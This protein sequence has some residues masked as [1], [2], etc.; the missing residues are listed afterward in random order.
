[1]DQIKVFSPAT[2]SNVACGFDVLGFPLESLGD[3]MLVRKINQKGIKIIKNTGYS[4][5]L[6]NNK[7]VAAV[8]AKNFINHIKPNCGFEIE[9]HK[10]IKPGSEIIHHCLRFGG[11]K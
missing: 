11:Y 5:P 1:M 2:V 7:N 4:V 3:E 8:A 6:E 9:I 10:N